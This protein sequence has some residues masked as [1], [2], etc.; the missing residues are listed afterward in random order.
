MRWVT[1]HDSIGAD[2]EELMTIVVY[3]D[4]MTEKEVVAENKGQLYTRYWIEGN[5]N[6]NIA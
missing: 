2:K 5:K 3:E 4:G 6:P 1:R